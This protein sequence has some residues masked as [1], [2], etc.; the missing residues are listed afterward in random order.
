MNLQT[1]LK[2]AR[3]H[4]TTNGNSAFAF[5]QAQSAVA[6]QDFSAA[7]LWIKR[8]VQYAV[9]IFHSDYSTVV[10]YDVAARA[11]GQQ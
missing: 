9:G 5:A 8:T 3:Q 1:N 10:G 7:H 4:S 6:A 11:S 2:I